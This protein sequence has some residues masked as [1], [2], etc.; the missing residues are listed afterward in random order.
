MTPSQ[1]AKSNTERGHQTAFFAFCAVAHLHGFDAAYQ[2]DAE[3][4]RY[5]ST[6][7]YPVGISKVPALKWIHAIHNQGH[8]DVIRGA[9]AKAEGL[10]AGV[11][12]VFLPYPVGMWHGLYIEMKRPEHK[13][14]RNGAS[15]GH[16]S[17]KQFEF[18]EYVLKVGYG[19]CVCYGWREA[20]A[21]VRSYIEWR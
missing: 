2:W 18:S 1:L 21:M 4:D 15:K 20:A 3:G 16:L 11:A 8:G 12:D 7:T 5:L 19:W 17:Q 10:R 14:K 6:L 13:P 9:A